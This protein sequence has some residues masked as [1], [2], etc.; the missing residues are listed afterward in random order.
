MCLT[1]CQAFCFA[2]SIC[3][4]SN[5][6]AAAANTHSRSSHDAEIVASH[7]MAAFT[8][9]AKPPERPVLI[10]PAFCYRVLRIVPWRSEKQMFWIYARWVIATMTDEHAL[11]N[12]ASV[13][14]PRGPMGSRFAQYVDMAVT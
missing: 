13:D 12:R 10:E 14:S 9:L 1:K 5:V 11:G 8:V 7:F 4:A 2:L 6:L 3:C